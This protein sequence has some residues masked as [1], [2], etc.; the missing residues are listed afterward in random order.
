MI[1]L[2]V[3]RGT[4]RDE[5]E[6]VAQEVAVRAVRATPIFRS[7]DELFWWCSTVAKR[8]VID[9]HRKR[10]RVATV[11]SVPDDVE[12]DTPEARFER[13]QLVRAVLTRLAQLPESQRAA[14]RRIDVTADYVRRHR[15][16]RLLLAVVESFGAASGWVW[17]RTG[18]ARRAVVLGATAVATVLVID[19][20]GGWPVHLPREAPTPPAGRATATPFVPA[21]ATWPSSPA[22]TTATTTSGGRTFNLDPVVVHRV[23]TPTPAGEVTAGIRPGEPNAKLLCT[24]LGVLRTSACFDYPVR[25]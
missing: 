20:L 11:A 8:Y 21:D 14:I 15:A 2:V 1:G 13:E 25:P 16:R 3:A 6:D 9:E 24:W 23:A 4:S 17:R 10:Y 7:A 12:G 18:G 22:S 19:G 5:A